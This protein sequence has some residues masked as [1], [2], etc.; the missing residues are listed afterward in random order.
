MSAAKRCGGDVDERVLAILGYHK[1]GSPPADGWETWFYIPE[2][3]FT[4]HLRC[5]A[6]QGWE[7]IDLATLLRG[8]ESP[9]LLPRRAAVLTFDDGYRSTREVALPVLR[10]FGCPAVLFVPTDFIG[11]RNGFD[12]DSEPGEA[13]CTWN[14]LRELER[15]GVAVQSHGASHRAFSQLGADAQEE[16]LVR[17]K[18]T[19]ESGLGRPV[20][21]FS[22]PYGDAGS[23]PQGLDLVLRRTGYRAAC[24][25]QGRPMRLPVCEPYRL[26]R[27]AMGPDTDLA[28]ELREW[29]R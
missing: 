25:Y 13:I 11:G 17:S 1:I 29:T 22:Y 12:A 14:D 15:A 19:L 20:E 27:I 5:L 9:R 26:A 6:E 2:A 28:E 24:L 16:E 3:T 23:D 8:L 10:R 21:C 7:V 4:G 18:R